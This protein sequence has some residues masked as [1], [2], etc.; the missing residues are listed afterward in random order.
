MNEDTHDENEDC[1]DWH[2]VENA[3][4][5][6]ISIVRMLSADSSDGLNAL[7]I[8]T[9][10]LLWEFVDDENIDEVLST[11]SG[12]AKAV[13]LKEVEQSKI[14]EKIFSDEPETVEESDFDPGDQKPK[15]HH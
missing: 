14:L 3:I 7:G 5:A 9:G 11:M 2:R 1:E 12:Q 4:T 13:Y 8:A 6:I 10:V 15:T